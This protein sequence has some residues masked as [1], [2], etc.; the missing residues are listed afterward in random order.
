MAGTKKKLTIADL[1]AKKTEKEKK[2]HET[3][4]FYVESLG[5]EV[6]LERPDDETILKAV[7]MFKDETLSGIMDGYIFLIYNSI[8]LFRNPELHKEYEVLDPL[9]IVSK[10]LE[11]SERMAIGEEILKMTRMQSIGEDLKN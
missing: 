4:S 10:L 1:I 5:G 11:L 2:R 9:D 8:A 6:L 7:D 3:K